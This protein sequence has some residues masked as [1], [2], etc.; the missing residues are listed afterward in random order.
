[1]GNKKKQNLQK[2]GKSDL[3]LFILVATMFPWTWNISTSYPLF[4][5]TSLVF[6]YLF[7]LSCFSTLDRR[8]VRIF[9]VAS[10]CGVAASS[11]IYFVKPST[12]LPT[13]SEEVIINKRQVFFVYEMGKVFSNRFSLFYFDVVKPVV[14]KYMINVSSVFDLASYF[15]GNSNVFLR[16]FFIFLPVFVVGSYQFLTRLKSIGWICV[17]VLVFLSGFID[18][19]GS[20]IFYP[21]IIISLVL[22]LKRALSSFANKYD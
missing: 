22:G 9:M 1:M 3:V 14:Y 8:V 19:G 13:S 4:F 10:F 20:I 15:S 11:V 5:I 17:F 7:Y 21:L 12:L 16:L 6:S 2:L 18:G